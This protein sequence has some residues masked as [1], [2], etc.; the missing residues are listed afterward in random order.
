MLERLACALAVLT[1]AAWCAFPASD[2]A[3][4][5]PQ[6]LAFHSDIDNSEQPYAIYLPNAF[7]PGKR[8]PVVITLHSEGSNHRMNLRQIFG[9]PQRLGEY[10]AE[11][12]RFFPKV[13]DPGFIIAAPLARGTMGY[14]GIAE[15][16]VY[17][18]LADVERRFPVDEDRV[19]LTGIG[20]GGGGALWLALTRPDVWAAV[21]ALCPE[22]PPAAEPFAPNALDLPIRIFHGDQDPLVSPDSS[23]KWHRRLL[24]AGVPADYIEY[25]GMRHN[26]WDFAYKNGAIFEWFAPH[27]RNRLP[28]HVHFVT[29]SYRYAS[30]YWVR[31]DGLTPG[32]PA[33]ID[34][35]R[36]GAAVQVQTSG[37][38]GFTMALDRPAAQVT[39]DGAALRVRPSPALSFVRVGGRWRPGKFEASR[40]RPGAEGPIVEAVSGRQIYVFGTL[41][42]AGAEQIA[43]RRQ[44]AETAARWSTY[45]SRLTVELPVKPDRDVSQADLDSA[46]VILFGTAA[47]N[48]L[49]Q[50]LAP[51]LP[52][53]LSPAAADYGLLFIAPVGRHYALVS[54]GLP[55]W[56]GAEESGRAGDP[57]APAQFQ[58]L[59]TFGDYILFKGTL[60]NVVAEGRFDGNWKVPP[61]ASSKMM[62]TGTVTIR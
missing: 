13:R 24:D 55:W 23:R 15:R 31:I 38:T 28:E 4:P 54:S 40:K 16:D 3:R 14:Q 22:A 9:I 5:G 61:D 51:Q 12:M 2:N 8:Y 46:D 39:V 21:A 48:S 30:A 37:V 58:L 17:D 18:V 62:A 10:D 42:P 1:C 49:I 59:S 56:T 11:D 32:T 36:S 53:A 57:M 60:A 52:M 19:Y 29:Q 44:V 50:K 41:G 20:M 43:A 25:P 33:T 7:E 45:R 6:V 27:R 35:R 34:A 47:T 26:V